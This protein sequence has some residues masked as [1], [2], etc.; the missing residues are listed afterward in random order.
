MIAEIV[1]LVIFWINALLPSPSVGG[2]LSPRHIITGLTINYMKHFRLQ[3]GDYAQVHEP[4]NNT[5]QE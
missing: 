4:H 5:I 1:D 3:F 2:N